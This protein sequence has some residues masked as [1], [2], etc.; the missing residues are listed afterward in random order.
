VNLQVLNFQLS[1]PFSRKCGQH[2]NLIDK[3]IVIGRV[4]LFKSK[5][6]HKHEV[7]RKIGRA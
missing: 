1:A 4:E 5:V 7:N 3:R 2:E 6:Q